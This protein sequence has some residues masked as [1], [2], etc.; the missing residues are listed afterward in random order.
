MKRTRLTTLATDGAAKTTLYGRI[1]SFDRSGT[2]LENGALYIDGAHIV[3]VRPRSSDPPAGFDT[4]EAVDTRG[5]I[6]PALIELHNHPAYNVMPMWNVDQKYLDRETWRASTVY[7]SILKS[8]MKILQATQ[9]LL[10]SLAR[11][12]ES[13]ALVSGVTT[14]QGIPIS[15]GSASRFYSGIVRA[16]EQTGR[17][18]LPNAK[19]QVNDVDANAV[20]SFYQEL[21]QSTSFIL[22]LSEGDDDIARE[23]FL[24]MHRSNGQWALTA[25]FA[26][27]HC[28]ALKPADFEVLASFGSSLIWSPLSNLLLYGQ[29]TDIR[30]A[31]NAGLAIGMGADWSFTGSKNAFSEL[32]V[33]RLVSDMQG[34]G[35]SDQDI[36]SMATRNAAAILKWDDKLGSLEPNKLAD[37]LVLSGESEDPYA[38]FLTSREE[39][40]SLVLIQ[41]EPAFG[42]EDF[43]NSLGAQGEPVLIGGLN[44]MIATRAA[45]LDPAVAAIS[46]KDATSKLHDALQHLPE[47][48]QHASELQKRSLLDRPHSW[49]L[50]LPELDD[51]GVYQRLHLTDAT[52]PQSPT[53]PVNTDP[54]VLDPL[55]VADDKN[56]FEQIAQQRN[57]PQAHDLSSSLRELFK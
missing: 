8:P 16:V 57:V 21:L 41:G 33:I 10:P 35:L 52:A 39:D 9:E 26:G 45:D 30:A 54:I 20:D 51:V 14:T 42:T 15:N 3:S 46:L 31:V 53:L 25:G 32:K 55:T 24:A 23:H 7:D 17:A 36:I 22:H 5:T 48:Q 34:L 12:V 4:S 49:Q 27:I 11:F 44:R 38:Q 50:L 29:T 56:Y 13:K 1:A 2:V 40:I 47:L 28:V 6:Y 43:M 18:D 37:L 19:S